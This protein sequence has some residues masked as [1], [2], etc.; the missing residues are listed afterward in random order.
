[1]P[2]DV[3]ERDY[4]IGHVLAA[5]YSSTSLR[6]ALV[7][8]GG[9]ALKKAYF[10]D[11]R[12]S[13]DLDFT[14]VGGA[15]GD[16]LEA[17]IREAAER[18]AAGLSVYG[19]FGVQAARRPEQ[20]EHPSGQEAFRLA[21]QFPWHSRPLCSIK[22]EITVDEPLL[23]PA[24]LLPLLHGYDEALDVMLKCYGLEEIVA[25]KLRTTLQAQKRLM[26]GRWPRNCAR[27]YYDLW[28][29]CAEGAESVD[30]E[31][32]AD[33]LPEKCRVR[34][35]QAESAQDFFPPVV[36]ETA[37]RQWEGSLA[38]LVRPLPPFAVV[39]EGLRGVLSSKLGDLEPSTTG[40]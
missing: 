32:V 40:G 7:F 25:E 8:K 29:L 34:G 38:N 27:D 12:F 6:E 21:I 22:L 37:A 30:L 31:Q 20:Q 4:A 28:R 10:G 1:V 24:A 39:Q 35:V 33:I 18:V 19:P 9:T 23:L 16:P 3:V 17:H 14:A 26:E 5:L 11:Y 36:V 2:L 15:R 13:V